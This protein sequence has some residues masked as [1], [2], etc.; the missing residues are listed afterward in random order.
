MHVSEEASYND[1]DN[2]K[3]YETSEYNAN[4]GSRT[5]DTQDDDSTRNL[6]DNSGKDIAVD[7]HLKCVSMIILIN[8]QIVMKIKC[9]IA[10]QVVLKEVL[11][12]NLMIIV[13]IIISQILA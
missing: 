4:Y 8:I 2:D 9:I 12:V 13:H 1:L 5:Y 10:S 7:V 3:K 11:T 6:V